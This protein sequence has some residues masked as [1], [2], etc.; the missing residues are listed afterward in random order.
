MNIFTPVTM[1]QIILKGEV[2]QRNVFSVPYQRT[3]Q[4]L[5]QQ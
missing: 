3:F 2:T 4:L 1:F 5:Y